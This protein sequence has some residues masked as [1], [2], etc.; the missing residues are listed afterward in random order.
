MKVLCV[1]GIGRHDPFE[2]SWQD[3]WKA[4][5]TKAL[6]KQ[7]VEFSFCMTDELFSER[8]LTAWDTL[9]AITMLGGN[10][11]FGSTQRG[12][13]DGCQWAPKRYQ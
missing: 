13:F 9:E 2:L 7:S 4:A 3:A 11:I 10:A 6:G 5:A 1:H 12:L 8:P